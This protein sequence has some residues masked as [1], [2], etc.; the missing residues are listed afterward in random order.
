MYTIEKFL[1][2]RMF[3]RKKQYLVRWSGY[4][5][6]ED[7]WEPASNVQHCAAL[8]AQFEA[9]RLHQPPLAAGYLAAPAMAAPAAAAPSGPPLHR[10]LRPRVVRFAIPS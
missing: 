3:H 4:G 7:S 1:E 2:C 5:P 6:D 10:S 9:T 8:L